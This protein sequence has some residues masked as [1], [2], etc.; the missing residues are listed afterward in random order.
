MGRKR[1]H[2]IFYSAKHKRRLV[3]RNTATDMNMITHQTDSADSMTII[4]NNNDQLIV[5]DDNASSLRDSDKIYSDRNLNRSCDESDGN[6][7]NF[8]NENNACMIQNYTDANKLQAIV[9]NNYENLCLNDNETFIH[10]ISKW[11]IEEK[12]SHES[13]RRLLQIL[14]THTN[15]T[16]PKDPRTLLQTPKSTEIIQIENG[17]YCHLGL[18]KALL[19]IIKERKKLN[20]A[21]DNIQLFINIDGLPIYKSSA[22]SLWPIL[23]AD[24]IINHRHI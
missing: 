22:K 4:N 1:T 16:L 3:A 18:E 9:D 14:Q 23:C 15:Y 13:L 24:N 8:L 12:I 11:A 5:V 21:L 7:I 10:N 20:I 2:S 19:K 6:N 17:D